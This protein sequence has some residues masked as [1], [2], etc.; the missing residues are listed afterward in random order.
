ME[1]ET[2]EQ[3]LE[4]LLD[5]QKKLMEQNEKII[6]AQTAK[7][8]QR[9]V[10]EQNSAISLALKVSLNHFNAIVFQAKLK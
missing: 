8:N 3:L 5:N 7:Q 2:L 10:A 9:A 4:Q 1:T 6:N